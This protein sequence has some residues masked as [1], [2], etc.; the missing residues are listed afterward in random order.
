MLLTPFRCGVD[1]LAVNPLLLLAYLQSIYV[2]DK[3][4]K[5]LIK[6]WGNSAAVRIPAGV[7]SEARIELEDPVDIREERGRIV[8]EPVRLKT[9]AIHDLVKGIRRS[10]LH[11]PVETGPP[12]GHEVW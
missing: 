3:T 11:N 1:V 8:I 5:G 4:V 12:V 2:E 6:K 10:N 9:F 7:L